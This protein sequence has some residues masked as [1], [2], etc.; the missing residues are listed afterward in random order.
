MTLPT[1]VPIEWQETNDYNDSLAK[2]Y[3]LYGSNSPVLRDVV[4]YRVDIAGNIL[5]DLTPY[6]GVADVDGQGE[7]QLSNLSLNDPSVSFDS[8]AELPESFNFALLARTLQWGNDIV[9]VWALLSSDDYNDG[10]WYGFPRG[11]Y[12]VTTPGSDDLNDPDVQAVT[13]YSKNVLLQKQPTDTYAFAVGSLVID[14]VT[15]LFID[16]G[17]ISSGGTL[18][19]LGIS[20][21]GD[22]STKTF[23]QP[24]TAALGSGG[25]VVSIINDVLASSG[26]QPLVLTPNGSWQILDALTPTSQG[27]AWRWAGDADPYNLADPGFPNNSVVLDSG[28]G[29]AADVFGTFNRFVFVQDG[30]DFTPVEGSGQYTVDNLTNGPSAQS[31]M[32]RVVPTVILLQAIDQDDLVTQGNTY[33]TKQYASAEKITLATESWPIAWYYDVFQF[34]STSLPMTPIRRVQAQSWQETLTGTDP[35]SWTTYVVEGT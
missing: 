11:H 9:S 29:Y 14:A 33:V 22:W 30:L 6:I 17:L 5:E 3:G 1:Y 20:F 15:Q 34:S 28:Q 7:N 18:G 16:A 23:A 19:D 12:V 8:T 35:M 2:L 32:G 26:C 27:L 24:Y 25:T 10:Q 13:G 21:P 4:V 31:T